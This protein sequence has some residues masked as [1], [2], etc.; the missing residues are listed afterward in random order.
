MLGIKRAEG[1]V[2]SSMAQRA[3][4]DPRPPVAHCLGWSLSSTLARPLAHAQLPKISGFRVVGSQVLQQQT[5]GSALVEVT[6]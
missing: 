4:G 3:W 5:L 2:G 6:H 1:T